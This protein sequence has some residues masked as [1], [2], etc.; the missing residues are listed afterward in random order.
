VA[1]LDFCLGY[2]RLC[3]SIKTHLVCDKF[4][5]NKEFGCLLMH[6]D[7]YIKEF[8]FMRQEKLW[9]TKKEPFGP[10]SF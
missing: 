8:S 5:N 4:I 1:S 2:L 9:K 3:F 6:I 7:T 10:F